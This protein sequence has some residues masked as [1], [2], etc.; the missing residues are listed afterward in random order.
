MSTPYPPESVK[1]ALFGQ[2]VWAGVIEELEMR[3]FWII[4][5]GF[6]SNDKCPCKNTH[7]REE[8]CFLFLFFD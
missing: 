7:R 6:K 8:G 5:V 2:R 3:L 4:R 1:V